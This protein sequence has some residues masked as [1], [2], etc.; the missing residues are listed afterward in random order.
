MQWPKFTIRDIV[1]SMTSAAV[2]IACLRAF[3]LFVRS[4]NVEGMRATELQVAGYV[5]IYFLGALCLGLAI[6]ILFHRPIV[7]SVLGLI[8]ALLFGCAGALVD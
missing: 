1:A 6:G 2:G 3:F 7:W 5:G 4:L 8:G